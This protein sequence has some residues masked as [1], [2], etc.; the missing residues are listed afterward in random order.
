MEKSGEL[1]FAE[2]VGS[3]GPRHAAGPF[4][5]TLDKSGPRLRLVDD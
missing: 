5:L 3:H 2:N 1:D 4:L